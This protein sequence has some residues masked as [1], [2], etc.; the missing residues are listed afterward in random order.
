MEFLEILIILLLALPTIVNWRLRSGVSGR[1]IL[2][3]EDPFDLESQPL[4][5]TVLIKNPLFFRLKFRIEE[6]AASQDRWS[7]TGV[8][9]VHPLHVNSVFKKKSG[10]FSGTDADAT[11]A[12]SCSILR[13]GEVKKGNFLLTAKRDEEV[14]RGSFSTS[15]PNT[16]MRIDETPREHRKRVGVGP[17]EWL[18]CEWIMLRSE[19]H[20]NYLELKR[21]LE[22]IC[23]VKRELSELSS[24]ATL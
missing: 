12:G 16:D 19:S 5:K 21:D 13:N 9:F 8:Y 3:L 24:R 4:S 18:P 17:R 15:N 23:Q 11:L 2:L 6:D 1:W 7:V 22:E 20:P 10:D 14:F